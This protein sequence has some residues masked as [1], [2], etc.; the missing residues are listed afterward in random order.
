MAGLNAFLI[1]MEARVRRVRLALALAE[2]AG[3]G[4]EEDEL[5]GGR[6]LATV[7]RE[8]EGERAS[9]AGTAAAA[10]ALKSEVNMFVVKGC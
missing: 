1:A 2:A 10:E 5:A 8:G 7:E 4:R 3:R 9:E 6:W